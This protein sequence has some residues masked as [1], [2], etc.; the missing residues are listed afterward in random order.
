MSYADQEAS[1]LRC[2]NVYESQ[3]KQLQAENK[4]LKDKIEKMKN[5]FNC[6]YDGSACMLR[7]NDF[8]CSDWRNKK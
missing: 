3:L 2:R 6:K 7:I 4:K 1:C 8:V 5:C